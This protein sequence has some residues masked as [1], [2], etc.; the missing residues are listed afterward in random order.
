VLEDLSNG[1]ARNE[2]TMVDEIIKFKRQQKKQFGINRM[3]GTVGTISMGGGNRSGNSNR[4]EESY[5]LKSSGD[6]MIGPL[7]FFRSPQTTAYPT[8]GNGNTLDISRATGNFSSHYI[9]YAGGSNTLEVISGAEFTGQILIIESTQT[10]T[11]TIKDKS[12]T[13]GGTYG[14]IKTLDGNDL[15]LGTA[16]TLVMFMYSDIDT[17]WHQIS[18]PTISSGVSL[19]GTNTWTGVNTFTASSFS[20]TSANIFLGDASS[21]TIHLTGTVNVNGDI[22]M[23]TYDIYAIDRLKFSTSAGSGSALTSSDTGLEALY[24]GGSPYGMLIQF[25]STNSAVMQIKRGTTE[26]V[27]ISAL[28]FSVYTNTYLGDST[29]DST[30]ISG[31]IRS[32]SSTE[33]GVF[34]KNETGTIGTAGTLQMP[35]YTSTTTPTNATL[36][37]YFGAFTGACGLFRD[38]NTTPGSRFYVRGSDGNWYY[39]FLTQQT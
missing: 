4:N 6:T 16:K 8:S 11:Q 12:N 26:V 32:S 37:T 38:T 9:W 34:I 28:G 3:N 2:K 30:I 33:I 7:A 36:D 13:S 24:S 27:N 19:S 1:K 29:S 23:N 39:S 18:N 14:N 20:V 5:S 25:P 22:D 31:R 17:N 35:E 21:D 15:A 10:L